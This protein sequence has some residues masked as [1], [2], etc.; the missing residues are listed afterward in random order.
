MSE[1]LVGSFISGMQDL[2]YSDESVVELIHK[3][4][5]R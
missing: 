5:K 1:N 2:G 3:A 4:L